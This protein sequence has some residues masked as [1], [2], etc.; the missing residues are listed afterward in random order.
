[1]LRQARDQRTKGKLQAADKIYEK[2]AKALQ[3]AKDNAPVPEQIKADL[4]QVY[5]ERGDVLK[6]RGLWEKAR[7]SYKSAEH[8]GHAEAVS[9]L[10]ALNGRATSTYLM[11]TAS[12]A[13]SSAPPSA[14]SSTLSLATVMTP[15]VS[16]TPDFLQDFKTGLSRSS[17]TLFFK[18]DSPVTRDDIM[19][20]V[21]TQGITN[22][23]QLAFRL[24]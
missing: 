4:A 23:L 5:I 11:P 8:E 6:D 12:I 7:D 13:Q 14:T 18:S 19:R 15:T 17:S 22:T 3:I 10:E 24:K 2:A 21:E 16:S 20:S 9:R 1:L